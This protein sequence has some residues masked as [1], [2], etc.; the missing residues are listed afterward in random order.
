MQLICI[1]NDELMS[2]QSKL[3]INYKPQKLE[4]ITIRFAKSA[5]KQC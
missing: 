2:N 5:H 4:K 3:T 1:D